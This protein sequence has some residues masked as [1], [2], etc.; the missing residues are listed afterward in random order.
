MR[1]KMFIIIICLQVRSQI[2]IVEEKVE[3]VVPLN[4]NNDCCEKT[5]SGESDAKIA[6]LT[7]ACSE[8][9]L[10]RDFLLGGAEGPFVASTSDIGRPTNVRPR[11]ALHSAKMKGLRDLLLAE[12]LNTQAISLQLTAQSQ[13][14]AKKHSAQTFSES[15]PKRTRRE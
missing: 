10:N 1:I 9:L 11:L 8:K 5:I 15:R 2:E 13:V 12:K 6:A 14:G 4:N 7:A 3:Q